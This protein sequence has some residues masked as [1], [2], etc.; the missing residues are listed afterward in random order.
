MACQRALVLALL[1]CGSARASEL[2]GP[3]QAAGTH[4]QE[5]VVLSLSAR[6]GLV[7]APYVTTAFPEVSGFATVLTGAAA[8]QLA[9]IGLLRV[10]LPLSI[11]GLDFPAHA[12]VAESALGNLELGLERR[13]ELRPPT[14]LEVLAALVVP[15]AQ[16]GTRAALLESR[17]LA[18]GNALDGGKDPALLTPGVSGLKLGARVEH[19][20][21]PFQLRARV[22][23]PVLLRV[24]DASLPEET[25]THAVGASPH[26]ELSA[27][28][29][30]SSWLGASLGGGVVAEPFRV[31][32]PALAR[33][34][35]R[36]LQVVLEPGAH[37]R[38]GER[39][40]L[41]LQAAIP[42]GGNLG[43]DAWSIAVH[44]RF[45]AW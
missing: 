4:L 26:I 37:A 12:Q 17:A 20:T 32:E 8:V 43:G 40:A 14:Q 44:G 36:R 9:P 24:S 39:V 27:A 18:L 34:R 21:H 33:D 35:E 3:A 38:L 41:G 29:W 25:E 13:V 11:V 6:A 19:S 16:H 1:V 5:R 31:Q 10:R 7:E 30:L 45:G 42:V 22:E 15:T 23:L 28:W 2:D